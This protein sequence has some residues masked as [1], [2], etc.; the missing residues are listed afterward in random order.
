M[1]D[2][3]LL[4]RP[5]ALALQSRKSLHYLSIE[6]RSI[7]RGLD[8]D[9]YLDGLQ[10]VASNPELRAILYRGEGLEKVR[11]VCRHP[12]AEL[13]VHEEGE[14]DAMDSLGRGRTT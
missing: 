13:L 11:S 6:G 7:E 4:N 14:H 1:S 3:Y 10:I 12:F 9:S 8:G 2:G 5:L